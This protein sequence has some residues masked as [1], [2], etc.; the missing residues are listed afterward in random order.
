MA[1]NRFCRVYDPAAPEK[2]VVR[3]K[4]MGW[5]GTVCRFGAPTLAD[6][7]ARTDGWNQMIITCQGDT[8]SVKVNGQET[9]K[10][11]RLNLVKGRIVLT[12]QKAEITYRQMD[13]E[14][15]AR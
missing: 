15:I 8:L 3:N 11:T 4:P 12:S 9:C 1:N 2:S 7:P 10:L 6:P 14:P 13:L 5:D